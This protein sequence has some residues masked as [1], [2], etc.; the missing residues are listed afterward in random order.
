MSE[1][2]AELLRNGVLGLVALVAMLAA[3]RLWKELRDEHSARILEAKE[4]T[5]QLLAVTD[6]VHETVDQ[7]H[8]LSQTISRMRPPDR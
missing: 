6:K 3:I 8:E 4:T 1:I 5:K 2:A 7:L